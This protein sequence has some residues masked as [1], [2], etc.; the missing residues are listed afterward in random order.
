M[1]TTQ[2]PTPEAT[3]PAPRGRG[4]DK[5]DASLFDPA[6]MRRAAVDSVRKLDPRLMARNPVMFVVEV[7]SVLTTIIFIRDLVTGDDAQHLFAGLIAVWLW[8]T[9]LFANFAEAMAEGRG[10]AQAD[11]LRKARKDVAAVVLD[12]AR[13][14]ARRSQKPSSQLRAGDLVL[15]GATTK[16]PSFE[17]NSALLSRC[18]VYVLRALEEAD[19]VAIM[20]RAIADNPRG[21]AALG[22]GK[23]V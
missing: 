14:D 10:K 11:S 4:K 20:R 12:E 15:V 3:E 7:G 19:L 23:A 17:V 5:E 16:N 2:H 13:R 9:V 1:T 22:H 6:I 18:R 8:F 21:L